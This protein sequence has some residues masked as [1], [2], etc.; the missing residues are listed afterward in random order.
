MKF[1]DYG[2]V[3]PVVVKAKRAHD[4]CDKIDAFGE[5]RDLIDLQYSTTTLA[6]G[7]VEYSA[8]ALAA[9]RKG[10]DK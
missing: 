2:E 10:T 3:V 1:R 8:L 9:I 4:L 5:E 7:S 6:D